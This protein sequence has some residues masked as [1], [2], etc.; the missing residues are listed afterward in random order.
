MASHKYEYEKA[1]QELRDQG[2]TVKIRTPQ[3]GTWFVS[4]QGESFILAQRQM[5]DLRRQGKLNLS[6]IRELDKCLAADALEK[7]LESELLNIYEQLGKLGYRANRFYQMFSP[8]CKNHIGGRATV[9]KLL[10]GEIPSQGFFE[11]K[12][13]GRLDISVEALVLQDR[14]KGLFDEAD[15]EKARERLKR[16]GEAD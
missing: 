10:A 2:F 13:R 14:W 1:I 9:K 15:R 3:D 5:V 16:F 7:E 6:G 4:K 12:S 11:A 8:H